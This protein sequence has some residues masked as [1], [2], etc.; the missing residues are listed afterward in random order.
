MGWKLWLKEEQLFLRWLRMSVQNV[1][2][3]SART[4]WCRF[5]V[6]KL[7]Q[8]HIWE[9]RGV[10]T[11]TPVWSGEFI[12]FSRSGWLHVNS[13]GLSAW[14]LQWE[15]PGSGFAVGGI[16]WHGLR[17]LV[18]FEDRVTAN[19]YKVVAHFYSNRSGLL[20]DANAPLH[21]AW[22]GNYLF[23]YENNVN[24]ML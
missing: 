7:R 20:Q 6:Y 3:L 8:I 23:K 2:R 10:N 12:T 18:P 1:I 22:E 4:T 5:A 19:Q 14:P 9:V 11:Q 15:D 13:T 21:R 24:H 16:Y 17:P